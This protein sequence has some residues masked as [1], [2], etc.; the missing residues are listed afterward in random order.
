MNPFIAIVSFSKEEGRICCSDETVC[1]IAA[2]LHQL[3]FKSETCRHLLTL[4]STRP[5]LTIFLHMVVRLIPSIA[6]ARET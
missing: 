5:Y 3:R 2:I 4:P 1:F 6:A